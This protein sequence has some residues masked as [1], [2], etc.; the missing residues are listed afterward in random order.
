GGCQ[1]RA[2]RPRTLQSRA[3]SESQSDD[4]LRQEHCR[5]DGS[6]RCFPTNI[7]TPPAPSLHQLQLRRARGCR[8]D[9]SRRVAPFYWPDALARPSAFIHSLAQVL[10]LR[11]LKASRFFSL[12]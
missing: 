10:K 5:R 6:L 7:R 1:A 2:D 9:V 8:V 12:A 4:G 3:R 11:L